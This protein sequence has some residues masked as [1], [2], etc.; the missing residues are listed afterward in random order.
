[1][2]RL[3]LPDAVVAFS[4]EVVVGRHP[5]CP[6][7]IDHPSVSRQHARLRPQD[8]AWLI[9][10]LQSANGTRLNGHPLISG[11]AP[12][13]DGAA[14]RF[15][16]IEAVFELH[17][18][19]D[20]GPEPEPGPDLSGAELGG[21]QVLGPL[22]RETSGPLWRARRPRSA[23][24]VLLW[25]LDPAAVRDE[26]PEFPSR[27]A[28]LMSLAEGIDHPDRT[29]IFHCGHDAARGLV[30]YASD[31]PPG[32]TLARLLATSPP[33]PAQALRLVT[34]LA[35]LLRE[36]HLAGIVHGALHPAAVHVDSAERV[37]LRGFGLL[38]FR[39]ENRRRLL[40]LDL[41]RLAPWLDPEQLSSAACNVRSDGYSLGC[42][43]VRMLTG[44]TPY[45]GPAAAQAEAHRTQPLPAPAAALRLPRELDQ[46]ISGLMAR[47]PFDRYD[48]L[49][50]AIADLTALA[51][52][53]GT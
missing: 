23:A 20:D 15:G 17:D 19:A 12:L 8:G 9:E 5:A 45:S 43:L 42:L 28:G 39:P 11:A 24:E 31:I 16:H 21:F 50:P 35:G 27:Y 36:Y 46:V 4:A 25:V 18:R 3:R 51:S 26:D 33:K 30:W 48:D 6:V 7:R 38:G 49:A 41:A 34:A 37:R 14:V 29:R 52:R 2:P 32:P 22:D 53:L 40:T 10:D 47:S 1:M 13:S 44:R